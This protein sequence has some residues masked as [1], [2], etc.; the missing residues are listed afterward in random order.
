MNEPPHFRTVLRGYDPEQVAAVLAD[1][2]DSLTVARRTAADR[3]MELVEVQQ[4]VAALSAERD[5]AVE[6]LAAGTPIDGGVHGPSVELGA[7]V[8]AIL[9]LA[10]EEAAQVRA[11][12]ERVADELRQA[13]HAE[14]QR[15]KA[16]AAEAADEIVRQAN[17]EA[18]TRRQAD[19][20]R[21]AQ[22]SNAEQAAAQIIESARGEAE[23]EGRRARADVA[24]AQRARDRIATDLGGVLEL[25]AQLELELA[26]DVTPTAAQHLG[27]VGPAVGAVAT[28]DA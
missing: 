24:T 15:M 12:A 3:T 22:L 27:D 9:S 5:E 26:D 4:R 8:S 11:E 28:A 14:A 7:R 1:L 19:A 21:Q 20:A 23:I 6:R 17:Q 18:A 2:A 16:A 25:L 13:A 10:N